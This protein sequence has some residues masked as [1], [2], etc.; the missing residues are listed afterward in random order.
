[1]NDLTLPQN[2]VS[3]TDDEKIDFSVSAKRKQPVKHARGI[4]TFGIIWLAFNSIF[5][6]FILIPLFQGKE[7]RFKRNGVETTGSLD[8]LA[9]LVLPI[10]VISIFILIGVAILA[11]GLFSLRQKGGYFVGTNMRLIQ[12]YKG[13]IRS[14]NWEQ[15]SG[16][17]EV[18]AYKGDLSLQ[19]RTGKVRQRKNRAD[20]FVPDVVHLAGIPDVLEIERICHQR[21]SE[22]DPTPADQ[23]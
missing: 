9:P 22:N 23:Q 8:N 12:Q 13:T 21:I 3:V 15:F 6:V 1:M 10:V 11:A 7:V 19:L 16:N 17:I 20:E 5:A 2:L 4:I 14:Y 18:D